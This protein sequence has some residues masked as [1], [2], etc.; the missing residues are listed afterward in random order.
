[1]AT[2]LLQPSFTGGELS[3]SLYARTDLARYATSLRTAKNFIVRPYGGVSNRP[4][5]R[6]VGE[7]GDSAVRHRLIPFI[8]STETAYVLELGDEVMRIYAN[9]GIV[10]SAPDTPVEVV[11]PWSEAD[12]PS[13]RFTQSADVMYFAHPDYPPMKLSRTGAT[14]FVL[15]EYEPREGPFRPYNTDEAVYMTA[16]AQTGA[17]TVTCNADVFTADMVGS[18]VY[19]EAKELTNIKPWTQGERGISVGALRRSDGKTYKAVT[20]PSGSDWTE[21]GSWRPVHDVGRAW[22]GGGT[23]DARTNGTQDWKV[24]I[25]WEYQDSGY[26]IVLI[27]GYTNATTVTG[28]VVRQLPAAVVGGIG[29]ASNTWNFTGDGVDTTFSIT[30]AASTSVLDYT[31]TIAG[32]PVDANPYGTGG[33]GCVVVEA[34][35]PDAGDDARAGEVRRDDIMALFDPAAWEPATGIVTYSERKRA[36]CVRITTARGITLSCSTTA[37]I[38]TRDRGLVLAPHLI[39]HHVAIMDDC[40]AAWDV[41]TEVEHIGSRAIQHI[42]VGDRCFWAGDEA[43]RYILHHNAKPTGA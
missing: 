36:E 43:G 35:V 40:R 15:D 29:T 25:E 16:S 11:T 7:V 10:E 23:T 28:V 26:G 21:T 41:V 6:F 12:L 20:V 38:P 2:K 27:T 18:F 39:G 33:G 22:D 13:L 9:A 1:M 24:G 31:V 8:Y 5:F 32:V 34:F 3:P 42:T 19:L 4:G 14:T 30:G 37:P 17:V